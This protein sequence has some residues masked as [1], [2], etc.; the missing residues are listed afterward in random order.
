LVAVHLETGALAVDQHARQVQ[1][2]AVQAQGLG[3][4][5]GVAAQ[6]HL[7]EHTGFG[8]VQVEAQI[9]GVYPVRRG[10]VGRT[11][12]HHARAIVITQL[13][14]ADSPEN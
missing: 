14:H 13:Q 5:V 12:D 6:R 8:G 10:C 1:L 4:H 7:V 11:V 2:L 9:D 3:R